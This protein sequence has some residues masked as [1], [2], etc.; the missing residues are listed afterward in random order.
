MSRVSAAAALTAAPLEAAVSPR[1]V[2]AALGFLA[3][4]PLGA[5]DGGY[6]PTA[7]SW[8]TLG[9]SWLAVLAL[10]L[11]ERPGIGRAERAL[12]LGLA[13]L[14]GWILASLL[15]TASVGRT[16][17]EAERALVYVGAALVALLLVRRRSYQAFLA[18]IWAAI[19][20]ISTYAVATR[21]FPDRLGVFDPI[22]GYR[23][24]EPLGYWNA[25][26]IFAVIGALL[27]LGYAARPESRV[28][29]SLAAASIVIFL[30]TIYFTFSRGAWIALGVGLASAI[31][32]DPRRL[33]LI[34]A[35]LALAPLPALGLAVAYQSEALTRPD[36]TLAA[37]SSDGHR[38]A[39]VL[40]LLALGNGLVALALERAERS[41]SVP[42]A[43]RTAYAVILG[44]LLVAA[45]AS[46][47]VRYGSPPTL[48][49]RAYDTLARPAPVPQGD[50]NRRLFT[51]S[52]KARVRTWRIA[53]ADVKDHPWLG[54]GAGTYELYWAQHRPA[55][56]KVRDAHS[57]YLET[58]A[59]L[60]PV[61]LLLVGGTLLIPLGAAIRARER[62]LV[63]AA[64]GAYVA[65]LVHAG[66]DWDWEMTAITVAA[67]SCGIALLVAARSG[68]P[69]PFPRRFRGALVI[70][71][72][73]LAAAGFVGAM[74][75]D[76][77]EAGKKAARAGEWRESEAHA[78][79]A[80]GWMPWA[81]DPWQIAGEAQLARGDNA[82]ARNT[83]RTAIAKDRKDWELWLD[84]SL[85]SSGQARREAAAEAV[86]LNPLGPEL[87]GLRRMLGVEASTAAAH[88]PG[89]G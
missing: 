87:A 50:L 64:V 8:S 17:L 89:G 49:K 11:R 82:G 26:G 70:A 85:A 60:G 40:I 65:Y 42:A 10:L 75:N 13:G 76:A 2:S 53:W 5:G 33:Q 20:L 83:L 48:A 4:A 44:L 27:A 21:V 59:E 35:A 81:S 86:R 23:L 14:V 28:T 56:T 12:V 43:V 6:W 25:L 80:M 32:L 34:T 38:L 84:L 18:G 31:A 69:E 36:A 55:P 54:S 71:A 47:F 58:L 19:C 24:S 72:L 57:L 29:R 22:A 3:V 9:F 78:R 16:V 15:W 1:T 67:L 88:E 41:V 77:L 45:V 39:I 62:N 37:A 61:G 74:G 63:P 52:S 66:V 79:D 30:A 68:E 7:W 46:V 51:L 73:A